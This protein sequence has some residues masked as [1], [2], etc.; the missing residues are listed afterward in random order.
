MNALRA[1]PL[2]STPARLSQPA[3]CSSFCTRTPSSRRAT[4]RP[5]ARRDAAWHGCCF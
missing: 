2:V 4:A 5:P 1:V 3:I